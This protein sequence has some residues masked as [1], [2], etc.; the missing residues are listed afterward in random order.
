[1]PITGQPIRTM[2]TPPKKKSEPFSLSLPKKNFTVRSRPIIKHR[3]EINRIYTKT[4]M[5]RNVWLKWTQ[6]NAER[7]KKIT[8]PIAKRPLSNRRRIPRKRKNM[9]KLDKP[10]P[11]SL[12]N[13][14]KKNYN[15]KIHLMLTKKKNCS[16]TLNVRK[17]DHFFLSFFYCCYF[18]SF[19]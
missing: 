15:N 3:P 17:C 9:P 18:S 6:L 11:I 14:L 10:I 13:T 8:L 4:I 19:S 5:L 2:R 16:L 1:M 7:M 12:N